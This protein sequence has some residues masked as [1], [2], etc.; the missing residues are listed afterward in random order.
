MRILSQIVVVLGVLS[1]LSLSLASKQIDDL[2]AVTTHGG[3]GSWSKR[4]FEGSNL[5][6]PYQLFTPAVQTSKKLPLVIYLHGSGEAGTDNEA[7]MYTGLNIGPDYFANPDNQLIQAAYVL[8]P[9]TPE[10]IRWANTSLEPY[11]LDATPITP[12]LEALFELL[13]TMLANNPQI[14]TNRIYFAGLSRGG[15]GTW[16]AALRR[17]DQ[18]AAIV[19]IAGSGSSKHADRLTDMAI[20]AFHGDNDETTEVAYTRAMIDALYQAGATSTLLRYSE[21]NRGNH[22]SSWL[23]AHQ[24]AEL[25]RWLLQW[26][27]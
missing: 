8:A 4:V 18:F 22:A 12:S 3:N 20:W 15:Q 5:S 27:R 1:L 16:N 13:D 21:V 2:E 10:D 7:Q 14:D 26:S 11:D 9:Q 6:L 17:P 23:T 24:D 19:P 25:Y